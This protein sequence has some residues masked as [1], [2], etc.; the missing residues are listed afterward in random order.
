MG[1]CPQ[2]RAS[3][4]LAEE[5]G[6]GGI[7]NDPTPVAEVVAGRQDRLQS[8]IDEFDRVL[9]GGLVPG[10]VALLGGPPGVGK[11]T[12]VLQ[13]GAALADQGVGVLIA[14]GE[15]SQSQVGLRAR[16]IGAVSAGLSVAAESDVLRLGQ[17][18]RSGVYPFVVVDSIQT[19]RGAA[20]VGGAGST[21]QIRDSATQLITAAKEAN[22]ALLLIGHVTK[23]GAIAGPKALEHMVDAVLAFD[24][25]PHRNL[26]FL[27]GTK[28][29]FGSVNEIGVF[30][31]TDRGLEPMSDPSAVLAGGRDEE[32]AGSVLFPAVD[33]RRSLVVEVQALVVPTRSAQPR[34]SVKGL[35]APRV[36]QVLAA[37]ERHGGIP[38][39]GREVYVSVMGGMSINEPAADLPTALAVASASSGIALGSVAAWGEVGLTGEVRSVGQADRRRAEV[40]RLGIGR[41][42]EAGDR[43]GL[44]D[45]LG[46]LGMTPRG[47]RREPTLRVVRAARGSSSMSTPPDH[48]MD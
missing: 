13:F 35:P 47:G 41:T 16:R 38:L 29:R 25:D 5:N 33:G 15:E 31:M 44:V 28:N 37:L 12:V 8:G 46:E 40:E 11:S 36:H 2:C 30:E 10:S 21:T 7:P 48:D 14:T 9:G 27:R 43:R 45:I 18:I 6:S 42:V 1:F 20:G 34:R 39:S 4:S 3:G 17:L 32:T 19:V 23:D 22:V 26:R 24:G